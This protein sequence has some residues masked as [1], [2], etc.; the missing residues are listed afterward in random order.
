MRLWLSRDRPDPQRL[1]A[2]ICMQ[3]DRRED[4]LRSQ[5]LMV[6]MKNHT[7]VTITV[8]YIRLRRHDRHPRVS[9][10][11][12]ASFSVLSIYVTHTEHWNSV[13]QRPTVQWWYA[14]SRALQ[15]TKKYKT[16]PVVVQ[17]KNGSAKLYWFWNQRNGSDTKVPA[18]RM[19]LATYPPHVYLYLMI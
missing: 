11:K 4:S 16:T 6:W 19:V 18:A 8:K 9:R 14:S 5:Q 3:F 15:N 1:C 13:T 10:F 12:V 7:Q 2:H 17:I